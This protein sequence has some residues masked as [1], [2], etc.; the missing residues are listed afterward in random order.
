MSFNHDVKSQSEFFRLRGF[1]LWVQLN[2]SVIFFVFLFLSD[3]SVILQ[4]TEK[5]EIREVEEF[6][7]YDLFLGI[8]SNSKHSTIQIN[9]QIST[10]QINF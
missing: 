7:M 1:E 8:S 2:T 6:A 9:L 3:S 10:V 4:I 5:S